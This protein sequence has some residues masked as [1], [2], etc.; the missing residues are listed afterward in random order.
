MAQTILI[1]GLLIILLAER[2]WESYLDR[3]YPKP[4]CKC[5]ESEPTEGE[6]P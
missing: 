5:E 1:L 2:C 6:T 4:S 3:K